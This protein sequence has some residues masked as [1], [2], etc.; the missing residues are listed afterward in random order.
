MPFLA[1]AVYF[2]YCYRAFGDPLSA[3]KARNAWGDTAW[4]SVV[5]VF[6]H[7]DRRPHI[8]LFV[9]FALLPTAGAVALIVT[10][11]AVLAAAVVPLLAV[12]WV[13]GAF[14]LGR[15]AASCWPAFLPVGAWLERHPRWKAPLLIVLALAQGWFFFLHTHHY[16]IQ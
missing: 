13:I 16:E 11:R 2:F 4:W 5:Q 1:V 7:L 10:R 14:G 12:L 9:V 6:K 8:A 15:Y 3:V